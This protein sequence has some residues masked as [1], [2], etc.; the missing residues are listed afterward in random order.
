[1][2]RV[3]NSIA[4]ELAKIYPTYPIYIQEIPT[5]FERPSFFIQFV[6]G[7]TEELNK[8]KRQDNMTFQVVFFAE[9][10]ETKFVNVEKQLQELENIKKPF[11]K[12]YLEIEQTDGRKAKITGLSTSYTDKDIYLDID[13]YII[14]FE[15]LS[16][17]V[18]HDY[19]QDFTF[20]F[21]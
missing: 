13:L 14:D 19:M 3:I 8:T 1:M 17:E 18:Q 15:P 12:G 11:K 7:D 2:I 9:R 5:E 21:K 10:D 6:A 16:E 20:K 4:R